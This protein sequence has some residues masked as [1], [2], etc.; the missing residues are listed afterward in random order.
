M[1]DTIRIGVVGAGNI[2]RSRHIPNLQKLPDVEIVAVANRSLA[3]AQKVA[4]DFGI[5]D[6][7]DDWRSVVAR[8]DI[9]AIV[10]GAPPY[11][12]LDVV[13]AAVDSGKD[14]LSETRMSTTLESARQMLAKVQQT[15]R[16]AALVRPS[17]YITGRRYVKE[18]LAGGFVG[19]VRQ[20]FC[21]RLIPDYTDSSTP[22]TSRQDFEM[23][24]ETNCLYLGYC[25]D[26]LHDWFGDPKRVLAHGLNFTPRRPSGPEGPLVEVKAAEAVTAIAEMESGANVTSVQSG[27]VHFGEDRIEIYGTEGT[28]VYK[29]N[30]DQLLGARRGDK[31]LAPMEVPDELKD[32]W[33]VERD[34]VR[35]LRGEIDE[36]FLSFQDGVDNMEYLAACHRSSQE[37]RWVEFPV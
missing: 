2:T 5:P 28:L 22:I 37:G 3:S 15:G 11:V 7:S 34:F 8:D 31:E 17:R 24:G 36:M 6:A 21:Y 19:D 33:T 9:D 12:H 14:V 13:A 30:R 29:A 35:L 25:W 27:L 32:S 18:L 10:M 23:Y 1:A 4:T 16:K 26:V 20:V